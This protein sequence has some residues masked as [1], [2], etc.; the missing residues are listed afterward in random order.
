MARLTAF[1]AKAR[2]AAERIEAAR[3]MGQQ[4]AL[5]LPDEAQGGE[6]GAGGAG[7][8]ARG[9]GKAGSVLREWLAVRGFKQPEE[10][11]AELAGLDTGE[12]AILRALQRTEQ[13]IAAMEG[14][15]GR[16]TAAQRLDLF[17]LILTAQLRAAEALL[18]YGLAKLQPEDAVAPPV[19]VVIQTGS[20]TG[21]ATGIGGAQDARDVTPGAI[22]AA[23]GTRRIGPP[24]MPWEIERIQDVA[25]A[26]VGDADGGAR[27]EGTSA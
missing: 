11:L 12:D 6:G 22:A 25:A 20:G 21:G 1:E 10:A 14:Q 16:V 27:T 5:P 13:V 23:P 24:P 8:A 7:R 3:A 26:A 2:E 4:L 9:K 15:H 17:R 19:Q 18:P